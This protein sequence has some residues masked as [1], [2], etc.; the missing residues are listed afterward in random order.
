MSIATSITGGSSYGSA[1]QLL[2]LLANPEAYKAQLKAMEDATAEYKKYVDAIG[3][4]TEI[5]TIRDQLKASQEGADA[6]VKEAKE[7]AVKIK[8][9]AQSEAD[10]IFSSAKSA[11]AD[12]LKKASSTKD[13]A[14]SLLADA[15]EAKRQAEAAQAVADNAKAAADALAEKLAQ[16]QAEADQALADAQAAKADILAKHQ[17]FIQGL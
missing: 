10:E 2:D 3:V 7:W 11:S 9:D 12:L 5:T 6:E 4:A 14:E 15:K 8:K 1:S 17:E 16:T 13:D